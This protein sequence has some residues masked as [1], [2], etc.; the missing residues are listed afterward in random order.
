MNIENIIKRR[1]IKHI[2][3]F[4][5]NKGLLGVLDSKLLKSRKRLSKDQRL[6]FILSLN[7]K[8]IL[9]PGWED[10]ANLSI[11]KINLNLFN[12]SHIHW[13]PEARWRILSFDPKILE[14]DNVYFSTTNNAYP[15]AKR[16]MGPEGLESLFAERV[17]GRY[18]S[19]IQRDECYMDC[20]ATCGQAEVL[21]PGELSTEFLQCI[22][23]Q[24][25]E[26]Q[27]DVYCQIGAV[28]HPRIPVIIKPEVFNGEI[29]E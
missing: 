22:F 18:S 1:K 15:S 26:D 19:V 11:S 8:R 10:Y 29:V 27:D 2:L 5:T 16:S 13:H 4:T 12:I 3:H 23:V 24:N 14:H 20:C 9:D 6:E 17:L 7:T 28:M 25:G 21:Y